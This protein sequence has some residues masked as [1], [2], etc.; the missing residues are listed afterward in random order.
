M[1]QRAASTSGACRGGERQRQIWREEKERGRD[2]REGGG[3]EDA[4]V[5]GVEEEGWGGD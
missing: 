5:E 1:I 4:G 2:E 3:G